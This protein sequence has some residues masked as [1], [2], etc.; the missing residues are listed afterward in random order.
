MLNERLE[1]VERDQEP[2]RTPAQVDVD[3][4][5]YSPEFRRLGGVTQVVPPQVDFQFHDRLSHSVKVAQVAATLA[6]QLRHQATSEEFR[7]S[8]PSGVTS[9]ISRWIDPDHCY[10]AGLAHD[11]G[12]PPFGHAGEIALQE[13]CAAVRFAY[14]DDPTASFSRAPLRRFNEKRDLSRTPRPM[15]K[16][17]SI[18]SRVMAAADALR[19]RSFEGNAQSTRVVAELS[20]RR[21]ESDF[22]L[23]LTWRSMAAIA[24][25]PWTRGKH[26]HQL[27][28]LASKWSFYD[29]QEYILDILKKEGYVLTIESGG[30]V[31][32]VYRWIESEIMDWADDISYAVH[33]LEDFFRAGLVPL[34]QI[35]LAL[36][37]ASPH[38][39]WLDTDFDFADDDE[40]R[41]GLVHIHRRLKKIAADTL[42]M[43]AHAAESAVGGAFTHIRDTLCQLMP[44]GPFSGT[45]SAHARLHDFGSSLIKY[46]SKSAF[47]RYHGDV[48]RLQLEIDPTATL[49]AEFFKSINKL[50]VIESSMLSAA[51]YGQSADIIALC[52]SLF[53][54]S[55]GW[56]VE[57]EGPRSNRRLP[58]R[59]R[60]YL[61]H[62]V[63]GGERDGDY[64][65]VM[66][67]VIDYVCGLSD[68]QAASLAAQLKGASELGVLE[69]R[70]LDV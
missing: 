12:H 51:Q 26:P 7:D 31:D 37:A 6:R 15:T 14:G 19:K 8:L 1:I 5:L 68:F 9:D 13:Y 29:D 61:T 23:N 28:K 39:N 46:L 24:K 59:L 67:R 44:R 63:H 22:G 21:P 25:Y 50:Y 3:R 66:I 69:G 32:T 4:V 17:P 18:E 34:H 40:I 20:F 65:Y 41:N 55:M 48:G 56:L 38:V 57:Y 45:R 43:D 58:P 60:E 49:V 30:R 70:W 52:E 62:A 64:S 53:D 33:D 16:R 42:R 35:G 36:S 27:K 10:L 54:L 47:L 2:W 11:L